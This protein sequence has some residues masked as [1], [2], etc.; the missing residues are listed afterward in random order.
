MALALGS[1]LWCSLVTCR[2]GALLQGSASQ[3]IC[4][5]KHSVSSAWGVHVRVCAHTLMHAHSCQVPR[6]K[7]P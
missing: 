4:G 6:M 1:P 2:L 5:R 3:Y 7:V